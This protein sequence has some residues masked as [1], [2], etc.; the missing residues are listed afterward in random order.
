M[1]HYNHVD[2][3]VFQGDKKDSVIASQT[4]DLTSGFEVGPTTNGARDLVS[5][6][7][8]RSVLTIA[9][10]FPFDN[11][12]Q[13]NVA[14]MA[15]QYICSVISS[16]QRVAMAIFPSGINSAVGSKL[17]PGSP[18]ALTLANWI[19]CISNDALNFCVLFSSNNSYYLG[20]ELLRS[21]SLIGESVL[22]HL[23]HH[24]DA[25]LCCSLKSV[26]VFIF[27]N[28]GGLDMLETT[29]VALQDIMWCLVLT[30][31]CEGREN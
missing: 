17:S 25:I 21:D 4:L 18:E 24:Q 15:R 22:K 23:W 8:A 5:C 29:W 12:L 20:A 7:S 10:Q 1:T 14:V 27:A 6:H 19:Y 9:F 13:D 31:S 3:I 26:P 11:S 2:I 30:T 28:Q 16:V